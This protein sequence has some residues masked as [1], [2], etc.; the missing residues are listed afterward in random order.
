M[1]D[2]K[3]TAMFAVFGSIGMLW[4]HIKA[5]FDY[6]S[7]FAIVKTEIDDGDIW[8]SVYP[9]MKARYKETPF[10]QKEYS[11]STDYLRKKARYGRFAFS[12][13]PQHT[14]FFDGWK[15]IFLSVNAGKS[16]RDDHKLSLTFIR[17]TF[18]MEHMIAEAVEE[19]DNRLHSLTKKNDRF[20]VKKVFGVNNNHGDNEAP[21]SAHRTSSKPGQN[22]DAEF[23]IRNHPILYKREEIGS[24]TS[25][26]PFDTLAYPKNVID[27]K[28]EVIKWK[29][30]EGW[31][32][33]RNL[34]WRFGSVF[35]GPPGTG[36]TSFA[37]AIGQELDMPIHVYD[38]T[39]MC[40]R[41]LTEFWRESLQ[42]SPCIVLF[43]DLDRVFDENKSVKGARDKE[44]LT[45]DCLL[46]CIN[47]VDPADGILVI[48]TANEVERLDPALGVPDAT[49]K[50][51]RPG[52]LDRAV[53]FGI[54]ERAEREMVAKRILSD[55]LEFVEETVDDGE[56][57]TGAQFESRC[58]K[59]AL[60]QYWG[61]KV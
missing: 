48:V 30:S 18:N 24:P 39:T 43:E 36:K 11:S 40:N 27:F 1:F 17:G 53:F 41:Q 56:G 14:I 57:E 10:G 33:A 5:F 3:N 8:A 38:L 16:D 26:T 44:P 25:T 7:S 55:C 52:R 60:A 59:I 34:K 46:N 23:F 4:G 35:Y 19:Y 13:M 50:S 29:N 32:K 54:L 28:E 15:P 58:S 31:Y 9:Y 45:L 22:N 21:Q 51:T 42:S 61:R 20:Y 47:G 49:G 37:R 12:R 2:L 6:I